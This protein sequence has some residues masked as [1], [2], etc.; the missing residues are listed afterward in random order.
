M[1]QMW[2]RHIRADTA[3]TAERRLFDV[4]YR[5]LG[6]D[7]TVLHSLGLTSHVRKPWA[8]IDFV[9]IG[10]PGVYCIEVKGGRIRRE[11]GEW[12]FTDRTGADHRKAEGPF[13]QVG[14]AAA[15]L[16]R[17]LVTRNPHL[18]D[19]TVGY[20]IATP[21]VEFR[22]EGPDIDPVL[23]YD[24]TDTTKPFSSF[25]HRVADRWKERVGASSS[26][27]RTQRE[28]VVELTRGDFDLQPSLATLIHQTEQEFVQLTEQQA[29][30]MRGLAANDRVLVSGG[31]G[32]G[33]TF[34]AVAEALRIADSEHRV[35]L[36]CFSKRLAKWLAALTTRRD[37]IIVRHIHAVMF[38]VVREHGL[39]HRLP[40]AE[41]EDLYD[42]FLPELAVEA[43]LD[44]SVAPYDA[45]VIDEAQDMLSLANLDVLDALVNG[46][47]ANGIWR[48]FYDGN[49]NVFG[50]TCPAALRQLSAHP[51]TVFHLD[52]N[53]R[54]TLPIATNTAMLACVA[55][56]DVLTVEG[57]EVEV[58][59]YRDRADQRRQLGKL[60]SRRL[61]AGVRASD[62][63]VL[64]R[65]TFERSG[66]A[67]G[68]IPGLSCR[69]EEYESPDVDAIRF[70][71]IAAFK[72]LESPV[73]A[74]IDVD[75]LGT[76]ETCS[77]LYVAMSRAAV[78]LAVFIADSER[79][80]FDE[81]A[82]TFGERFA[83]M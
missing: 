57:P 3:S 59:W 51:T 54:N 47:I 38:D 58:Y 15:A 40:E 4:L 43:L 67:S 1:A 75:G 6:E 27:S 36:T 11:V 77:L 28:A 72:G 19:V 37:R 73:V 76:S 23:V 44:D 61:S 46:G 60:L 22:I 34:L 74:V 31:A 10:P 14:P 53:C 81:L 41:S 42:V 20:A 29:A 30:T 48:I 80:H 24:A 49:Q 62:I 26:L 16:R 9:L 69:V 2:P 17:Y 33:K 25:A 18:R 64:S 82:R 70:S 56:V 71:T 55:P 35:L 12:I 32:T 78:M 39:Q 68:N 83:A 7:W 65:F 21:D 5:E 52:V 63:V 79:L 8:E 66:V 45:I 13:E 50:G